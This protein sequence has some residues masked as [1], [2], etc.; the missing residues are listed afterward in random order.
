MTNP[1]T[2]MLLAAYEAELT[3]RGIQPLPELAQA[4][5]DLMNGIATRLDSPASKYDSATEAVADA[6]ASIDG[7]RDKFWSCKSDPDEEAISGYYSGYMEDAAELIRRLE[8]RG[9]VLV[10]RAATSVAEHQE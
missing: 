2:E 5:L 10:P 9:Y 1:T 4:R 7:K 6:W 8:A 3:A